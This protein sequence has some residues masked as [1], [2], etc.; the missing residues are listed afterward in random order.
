MKS[1]FKTL[2]AIAYSNTQ[3]ASQIHIGILGTTGIMGLLAISQ[4]ALMPKVKAQTAPYC[5]ILYG[6]DNTGTNFSKIYNVNVANAAYNAA[7]ANTGTVATNTLFLSAAAALEPSTGRLF[8][9]SRDISST[10]VAYWDPVTN[11]HT[12]LAI[13]FNANSTTVRAAFS[14][15]GRLFVATSTTLFEI[16]PIT[17]AQISSKTLSGVS[18]AN[19]DMAF[20]GNNVLFLAA[21]ANLYTID[22]D[23]LSVSSPANLLATAPAGTQFNSLAFK[24]DGKLYAFAG[25]NSIMYEVNTN[26]GTPTAIGTITFN[27]ATTAGVVG[28]DYASCAAPTPNLQSTKT[29]TKVS[30]ST[31]SDILPGDVME[32]T[33]TTTNIG[34]VPATKASFK[35]PV[36]VGT[37]YIAAST[38]M[39]GVAVT[40]ATGGTFPFA[41]G[42]TIQSPGLKPGVIGTG[43]SYKVTIKYRI[44]VNTVNPPTNVNN[45]GTTFYLGNPTGGMPTDDPNTL[46]P[47]DPTIT[48]ITPATTTIS[49][50]LYE[51]TD[52]G[53]DLD[54]GEPKLPANITVKLLDINN[55]VITTT[56][57]QS[58]GTYTFTN[59]TNGSYKI[60]VDTT[61]TDIAARLILGTNNNLPVT[62]SG[63]AV[64]NQNF[65][66]YPT[67]TVSGTVYEDSD[68]GDDFDGG[69]PTLPANITVKLLDGTGTI[70]AITNTNTSGQYSFTGMTS[71]NYIIQV[72]TNDSDIPAGLTL[73]TANSLSVNVSA[74]SV[75]NQN[76]GF[77]APSN[78]NVLLIKR[79]TAVNGLTS[80][81]DG[82][83]LA[84]YKDE[85]TN[86]YDDNNVSIIN[87][88]P[89][90]S[91]DTNKWPSINTFLVGGTNGGNVRPN[92]EIEYTIYYL[93]TGD[94]T[95][96][97]V[98]ICDRVPDNA[99]FI[100]TAFNNFPTKN[101]SGLPSGDRGII[102]QYNGA[103]ESLTNISDGDTAEYLS[104]GIDPMIKY[105]GIKCDG[106]NTNGAIVVKLGNLP[107]ATAPGIPASS[108]GFIRFRGRVK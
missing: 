55:N 93:S 98:L 31:G 79:I 84:K 62:V 49:G 44:R 102:W 13:T 35:D 68:R 78:P 104:P 40:D 56:L 63:S 36:P 59:I 91:E 39:N 105:P 25:S 81:K 19:G 37:T 32:Y 20:D 42:A 108:Y 43:S 99:T 4:V 64:N 97:N 30:G 5:S 12:Q 90:T 22:I 92:D 71:G 26:T 21:D 54:A 52:M 80:T 82:D 61:D 85:N 28:T 89:T 8:Y 75:T 106:S 69:E 107:N 96:N 76:F 73:G 1:L 10:K 2:K 33:I 3:K 57:T 14:P 45:Q 11:T 41:N 103:T 66:F 95:A 70:I 58:N 17:G 100:P 51:D 72:D 46:T 53:D 67:Y 23:N 24:P 29:Y 74:S 18:G 34:S 87:P 15:S 38:T 77:D 47:G 48:T 6:I 7:T 94:T 50:T 9:V 27:P 65:G 86:P 83:D 101:T 16:N 88:T 60:Q